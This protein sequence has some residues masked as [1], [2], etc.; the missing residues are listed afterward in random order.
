LFGVPCCLFLPAAL[1]APFPRTAKDAALL[2]GKDQLAQT[3]Y[4]NGD[5]EDDIAWGWLGVGPPRKVKAF[6]EPGY[7]DDR[8]QSGK[9]SAMVASDQGGSRRGSKDGLQALTLDGGGDDGDGVT[10]GDTSGGD[11]TTA[12]GGGDSKSSAKAKRKKAKKK[13]KDDGPRLPTAP[14]VLP[15]PHQVSHARRRLSAPRA[16]DLTRLLSRHA[17]LP[18]PLV[19]RAVRASRG[20]PRRRVRGD[21]ASG[22]RTHLQRAQV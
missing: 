6:G 20:G 16:R 15:V 10:G 5:D 22:Q 8:H 12:G 21:S 2:L 11:T 1:F 9:S 18:S 7:E 14:A 17:L 19:A 4:E 13:A 3:N